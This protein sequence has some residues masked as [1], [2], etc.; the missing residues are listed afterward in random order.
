LLDASQGVLNIPQNI[1][2]VADAGEDQLGLSLHVSK[3]SLDVRLDFTDRIKD[4]LVGWLGW[5]EDAKH[6]KDAAKECPLKQNMMG[7]LLGACALLFL[8]SS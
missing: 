7:I 8:P 3:A 6:I 1:L 2:D 5:A 4:I